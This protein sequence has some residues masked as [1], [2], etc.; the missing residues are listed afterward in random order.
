M[1]KASLTKRYWNTRNVMRYTG[2][3][4][5]TLVRCTKYGTFPAPVRLSLQIVLY[6]SVK[7]SLCLAGIPVN[8]INLMG[9][10]ALMKLYREGNYSLDQ[11]DPESLEGK[12]DEHD[13][14]GL[15]SDVP[16]D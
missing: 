15:V 5:S 6:D 14:T 13:L 9:E 16:E 2:L 1:G 4:Y 10:E 3:G 12:E 8:Q 7:I 11:F